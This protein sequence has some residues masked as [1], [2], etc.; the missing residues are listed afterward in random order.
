MKNQFGTIEKLPHLQIKN[1][2]TKKQR[3][4][5]HM[6]RA[7]AMLSHKQLDDYRNEVQEF[8]NRIQH[9]IVV[10]KNDNAMTVWPFKDGSIAVFCGYEFTLCKNE[11][12]AH[13]V[14][15]TTYAK[16]GR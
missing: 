10:N 1:T 8:A 6:S 5:K 11:K 9:E 2:D 3:N 16:Y 4:Q 7:F 13:V 15:E 12:E 14:I